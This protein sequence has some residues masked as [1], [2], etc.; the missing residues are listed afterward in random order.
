MADYLTFQNLIDE[1]QR[2]VKATGGSIESLI[3]HTINMVY[4]NELL[5]SDDL[6][7]LFWL[8][9]FDDSLKAK[10]PA[11]ITGITKA[12]PGVI[13]AAAHGFA[14]GDLITIY[15]LS[16]MTQLNNRT[17]RV[18]STGLATN[19]FSI[20]D[21]EASGDISTSSY[22]AETTGGTA[23]HRGLT[24]A[25]SGKNV[26]RILKCKFHDELPLEPIGIDE[27]ENENSAMSDS[28]SRP[29]RY[30]HRKAF[31]TTGTEVNQLLWF[32]AADQAYDLRY[33]FEKRPSKLETAATDV[34]LLPPQ[35]Q[36]GIVAGSV[37]RLSQ[38][39]VEVETP[40]VWPGIYKS[41][42][43]ALISF[44]RKHYEK[45]NI[46]EMENQKPYLL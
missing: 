25:T 41:H 35:F 23:H 3:K 26:Q 36:Y 15:G 18:S 28:T 1:V 31:T 20:T 39:G 17:F 21:L 2:A 43:S 6:Y 32:Q 11:T 45:A 40:L 12:A 44:N 24:L 16:E 14:A 8:T 37:M 10:A 46:Y 29:S 42:V 38:S 9:D 22:T 7:P 13:T 19:T 4:L 27:I 5:A 34:P 30:Y 33:W